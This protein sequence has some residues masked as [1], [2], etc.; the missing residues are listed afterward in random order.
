LFSPRSV[1]IVGANDR[2]NTGARALRN[3]I[4]SGFTGPIYPIN[5]NYDTLEGPSDIVR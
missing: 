4:G 5:P 2:G 1:A 3:V